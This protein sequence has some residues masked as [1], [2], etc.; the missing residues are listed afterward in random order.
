M[1]SPAVKAFVLRYLGR[2]DGAP[3]TEDLIAMAIEAAFADDLTLS[4]ALTVL[5]NMEAEKLVDVVTHPVLKSRSYTLTTAGQHA[6]NSL[7]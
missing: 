1:N 7:R 4:E 3:A 5:K 6:A 2:R